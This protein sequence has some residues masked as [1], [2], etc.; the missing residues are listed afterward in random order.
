MKATKFFVPTIG[1]LSGLMVTGRAGTAASVSD[2]TGAFG[3]VGN[4]T[5]IVSPR[6]FNANGQPNDP[7]KSLLNSL[8]YKGVAT[9][10]GAG[11][12]TAILTVVGIL[13]GRSS[14][15]VPTAGT[16]EVHGEGT[17]EVGTQG[18]VTSRAIATA[19]ALTGP[20]AGQTFDIRGIE[21]TGHMSADGKTLVGGTG[22][23]ISTTSFTPPSGNAV[24]TERI[25]SEA[26]IEV[27]LGP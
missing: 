21:F 5:C 26:D 19:K 7:E 24:T 20:R 27:K 18:E 8:T 25:C 1:L 22:M 17:Y 11:K 15:F 12:Y 2:L 6:G 16:S 9:Y 14:N 23:G 3:V 4:G 13:T 10:D